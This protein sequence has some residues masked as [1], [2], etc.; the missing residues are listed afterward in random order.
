MRTPRP[1]PRRDAGGNLTANAVLQLPRSHT[2][3]VAT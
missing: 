1:L 2:R 3:A